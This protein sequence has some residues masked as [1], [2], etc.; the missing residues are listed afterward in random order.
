MSEHL[1][2]LRRRLAGQ[3]DQGSIDDRV[4][5]DRLAGMRRRFSKL[6]HI[7]ENAIDEAEA[8]SAEEV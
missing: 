1:D 5:T 2:E 3:T 4:T 7:S 8:M 6:E